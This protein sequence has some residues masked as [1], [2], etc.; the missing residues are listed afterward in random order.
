MV[1]WI[2]NRGDLLCTLQ[3]MIMN[4]NI[5]WSGQITKFTKLDDLLPCI[6]D[7][8]INMNNSFLNVTKF[9]NDVSHI[10][11]MMSSFSDCIVYVRTYVPKIL[12]IRI[13]SKPVCVMISVYNITFS[14]SSRPGK[15]NQW[16]GFYSLGCMFM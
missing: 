1:M 9:P 10:S 4:W 6:G 13:H 2:V 11:C 16:I 7:A 5:D 14:S 15:V 12:Y 8:L 3:K